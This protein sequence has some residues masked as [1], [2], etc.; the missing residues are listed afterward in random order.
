MSNYIP[1]HPTIRNLERTGYP[2]GKIPERTYCPVCGAETDD[3]F[4]AYGEVIGCPECTRKVNAYEYQ[5]E[6]MGG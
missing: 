5:E 6:M 2:D 3:Y 4:V 1:D